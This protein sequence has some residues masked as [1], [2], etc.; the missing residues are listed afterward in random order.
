MTHRLEIRDVTMGYSE[1]I[2]LRDV[3]LEVRP[4]EVLAVIGPNGVGKSTLV[5]IASG[6][7]DPLSGQVGINGDSLGDLSPAERARYVS[8]VPQATNL[9]PTFRALDVV[10]MGRTPYLGWLGSEGDTDFKVVSE[11]MERTGTL[12]MAER[13]IG[14]LSGGEQ[15]RTLI[16]R[17]LAQAA[18]IM[19]LDEPTAHLDLRHQDQVLGLARGLAKEGGMAVMLALHDLNLVSRFADRVALLSDGV[20]RKLG[21][22][23]DVLQANLLA[24]VYGIHIEVVPSPIDGK[25]LVL[26]AE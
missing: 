2:V 23:E 1:S 3:S 15:Q 14:E 17:A 20:V 9:P 19:L 4:G 11:A 6:T 8:V 18:P 26:S 10:M 25:P 5:R 24:E 7:L 21:S 22:P 12:E 16:A 13:P